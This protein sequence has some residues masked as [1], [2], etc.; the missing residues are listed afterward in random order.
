MPC[1]LC[2]SGN[3]SYTHSKSSYHKKKLFQIMKEKKQR[4]IDKYGYFKY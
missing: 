3:R 1:E 4:A 2:G